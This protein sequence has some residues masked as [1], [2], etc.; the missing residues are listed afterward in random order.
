M[1]GLPKFGKKPRLRLWQDQWVCYF[2]YTLSTG[3][4][5]GRTTGMGETP[6][7]AYNDFRLLDEPKQFQGVP[8][9]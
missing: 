3:K 7:A 1:S 4:W 5:I 9:A 2:D 6:E 8:R